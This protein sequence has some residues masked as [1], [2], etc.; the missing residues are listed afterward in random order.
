VPLLK[1]I[2]PHANETRFG[3]GRDTDAEEFNVQ[4]KAVAR[5]I[6]TASPAMQSLE[7][8]AGA[9]ERPLTTDDKR[10]AQVLGTFSWLDYVV[11]ARLVFGSIPALRAALSAAAFR[12]SAVESAPEIENTIYYLDQVEFGRID[13]SLAIERQLIRSRFDLKTIVESPSQWLS[14]RDDFQ[15]W[16]QEYRLA[17]LEDHAQKQEQNKLLQQRIDSTTKQVKQIDLFERINAIQLGA[18]RE[19]SKLWDETVRSLKVC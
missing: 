3:G 16:R 2:V 18:M 10:L 15:R 4:L 5:R 19:L 13:H 8:A 9:I 11:Q 6:R 7:I 1:L 17:Y 14:L 12:W